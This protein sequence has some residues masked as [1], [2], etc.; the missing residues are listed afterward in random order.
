MPPLEA[1][2]ADDLPAILDRIEAL[3]RHERRQLVAIA[4]TPAGGK[5]T[6]AALLTKALQDR[7]IS[8]AT[9]PMDGFHLDNRILSE[10]DLL[11]R[12]GA[13]ETFDAAGFITLM[14]RL[15]TEAEVIYPVFDR[16]RDISVAG[17][18]RMDPG[19]DIAIVEGNYLL[20][21]EAPWSA[22]SDLWDL[23]IWVDTRIDTV[24]D[25]CVARWLAHGHTPEAARARALGNDV[26]NAER[27]IAAAR[28]ADITIPDRTPAKTA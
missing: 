27:I 18:E 4:G 14:T 3:P 21:D 5:S 23:T 9:V 13:P 12:K 15:R 2:F 28:P 16:Q 20:F 11:A 7:G 24:L 1:P 6:I 10:R 17:A 22:L 25:R 19:C 8:A 26:A